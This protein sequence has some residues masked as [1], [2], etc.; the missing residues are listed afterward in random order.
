[1]FESALPNCLIT[2]QRKRGARGYFCFSR[3]GERSGDKVIDEISLNPATFKERTDR[4]IIST[5]VHE[6]AHQWQFHFG[7]PGRPPIYGA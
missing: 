4:E 3:F 1:M 2:F 7:K 5:L 6:M